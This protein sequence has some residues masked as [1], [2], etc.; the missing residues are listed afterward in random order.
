MN[1]RRPS[2]DADPRNER[3]LR[4]LLP[5][6]VL[7]AGVVLWHLVVRLYELPPYVLPGPLLVFSTLV[8]DWPVL[9]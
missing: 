3:V 8:S 4:I 6:L 5:I 2:D 1:A 7:A 9:S